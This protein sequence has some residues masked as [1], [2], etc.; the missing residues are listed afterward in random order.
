MS[1]ERKSLALELGIDGV[2][3]TGEAT[4]LINPVFILAPNQSSLLSRLL[5]DLL[6]P[7]LLRLTAPT[8]LL[9]VFLP[10]NWPSP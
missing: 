9:L 1:L 3:R 8:Q 5:S 2:V 10:L 6:Q 4:K 7:R